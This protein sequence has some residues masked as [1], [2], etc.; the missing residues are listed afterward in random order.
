MKTGIGILAVILLVIG[1]FVLIPASDQPNKVNK[2]GAVMDYQHVSAQ[3]ATIKTKKGDIVLEL[4]PN[5]AP[6]TVTN[7]ATLAANG[8]YDG[9]TFHRVEIG[10]VQ[11]GDPIGDGTGGESIYGP[12]F[13]DELNPDTNSYKTGYAEGVI[14]MANRGPNTNSSQFFINQVDN[15]DK[16]AKAYTIFGRVVEGMD[17]VKSIQVDDE[18]ISIKIN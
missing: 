13:E 16:F 15:N 17:V 2:E 12:E 7:F 14:A 3:K 8:Y 10:I 6:K 9:L 11:G 4:Y 18:I 5:D 1:A